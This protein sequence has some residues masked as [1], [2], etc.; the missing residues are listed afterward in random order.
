MIDTLNPEAGHL[1]LP[2]QDGIGRIIQPI[3]PLSSRPNS[4][5]EKNAYTCGLRK[6][7][8]VAKRA[9][10]FT[11]G[12]QCA[13]LLLRS[14]GSVDCSVAVAANRAPVWPSG[15]V[16][17]ISH[18]GRIVGAVVAKA[19]RFRALGID[20]EEITSGLVAEEIKNSCLCF[21][22]L[23]L[24]DG[25]GLSDTQFVTLG[26][27]AKEALYKLLSPLV[28]C[29]FDFHDARVLSVEMSSAWLS[30]QLRTDLGEEFREGDV[31]RG[32]FRLWE[33]HVFTSFALPC[34]RR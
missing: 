6:E 8:V 16:G 18:S 3:V 28:G 2:G 30:L 31:I 9:H 1:L 14:F 33:G 29:Y 7:V 19:S 20:I 12:R 22:E 21:E 24:C 34:L 10:E 4:A 23:S 17:S 15:F 11:L 27:S 26:F 5:E 32:Q 13:A 25:L